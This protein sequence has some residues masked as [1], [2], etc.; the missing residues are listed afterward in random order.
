MAAKRK[1]FKD[2]PAMQFLSVP[3]AAEETV[4]EKKEEAAESLLAKPKEEPPKPGGDAVKATAKSAQAAR[5]ANAD[6]NSPGGAPAISKSAANAPP[7]AAP[8][9]AAPAAMPRKAG[10]PRLVGEGGVPVKPNPAYIETRSKRVQ[11]LM[12]PSLHEGLRAEAAKREVSLNDLVHSVLEQFL[13]GEAEK[14]GEQ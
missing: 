5:P 2:S 9:A 12:Q 1:S 4:E 7:T 11:L 6:S 14:T 13:E 8:A 10:R 3:E